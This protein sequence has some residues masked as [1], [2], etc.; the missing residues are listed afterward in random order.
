[1]TGYGRATATFERFD[2]TVQVSSVNKRNL[3]IAIA[4]P[5]RW[6][7]MEPRF[8]DRIRQ[9][10]LRGKVQVSVEIESSGAQPERIWDEQVLSVALERLAEFAAKRSIPFQADARLLW[11]MASSQRSGSSLP[12]ADSVAGL[13]SAALDEALSDFVEM[14]RCEGQALQNDLRQRLEAVRALVIRIQ[15]EAP[16][17]IEHHREALAQ[18]LRQAGLDF[19]LEDERVLKEIALFADRSDI[20]EELTRLASHLDQLS[21]LFEAEGEIGRK[22]D[23]IV[24]EIGREFHTVGSKANALGIAR[25]VI[26]C[27]NEMERIREQVQNV[28]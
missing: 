1:M 5:D 27:K 17:V 22:A 12:P 14:R 11:E 20:S 2:I 15:E 26:E 8:L 28:E 10:V 9:D 13:L 19:D 4:L 25:S 21:S 23:F 7:E 18:R 16:R 6:H 24:Q 3:D